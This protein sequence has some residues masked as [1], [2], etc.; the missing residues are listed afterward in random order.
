MNTSSEDPLDRLDVLLAESMIRPLDADEVAELEKLAGADADA[1]LAEAEQAAV[2]LQMGYAEDGEVEAMPEGLMERLKETAP[3]AA[4]PAP[5]ATTT[6]APTPGP[7][8]VRGWSPWLAVAATLLLVLTNLP[9]ATV[10]PAERRLELIAEAPGDLL[11]LDWTVLDDATSDDASGGLIWSD[12]AQEGYMEFRGL[13]PNDPTVE[14]YQLWIFDDK[15]DTAYPVDGGVFDI[16]ETG[17]SVVIPIDP[18]IA[19][20]GA[21]QFAITVEKPGGVV[22]SKRERIPLLAAVPN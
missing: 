16:P 3:R 5:S 22:V 17:D 8:R 9:Q 4:A 11:Q 19:V 14:Q 1:L 2:T 20:D 15:E 13:V 7:R 21:F 12:S 10:T 18:K 6:Q